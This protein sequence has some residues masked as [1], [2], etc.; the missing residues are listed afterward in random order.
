L[1]LPIISTLLENF[2][3][4]L[5]LPPQSH[6]P[7]ISS[8]F[9]SGSS[10]GKESPCSVQDPCLIPRLGLYPGQQNDKPLQYSCLENPMNRGVWQATV[11]GVAS[12][13]HNL[14]AKLPPLPPQRSFSE[15]LEA[16]SL[17]LQSLFCSK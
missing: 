13:R 16:M 2:L 3:Y 8:V 11:H 15:L 12:M 6:S 1:I 17:R 4:S 5:P 10:V 9:S 7:L 14:A